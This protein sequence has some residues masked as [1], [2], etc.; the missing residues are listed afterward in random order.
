MSN[1]NA[2]LRSVMRGQ[3]YFPVRGWSYRDGSGWSQDDKLTVT[4]G[5]IVTFIMSDIR[6]ERQTTEILLLLLIDRKRTKL[7][8]HVEH[9]KHGRNIAE[10][11]GGLPED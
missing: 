1:E 3:T 11:A 8:R 4:G 10:R 5:E 2:K 6:R 7:S 9:I